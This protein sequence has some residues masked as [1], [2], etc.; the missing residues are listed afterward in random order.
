MSDKYKQKRTYKIIGK[1]KERMKRYRAYIEDQKAK[2]ATS[3]N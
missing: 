3:N 2:D 1:N